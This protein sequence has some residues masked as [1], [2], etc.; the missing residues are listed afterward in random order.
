MLFLNSFD[1]YLINENES[2]LEAIE[3][4][5]KNIE[6]TLYIINSDGELK[7]S[8]SDGDFRRWIIK[9]GNLNAK[10][11]EAASTSLFYFNE[12]VEKKRVAELLKEKGITSC[13]IIDKK[14][15]IKGIYTVKENKLTKEK[16]QMPHISAIIMAGGIG[17]RMKPFTNIL[18]KPLI[19]IGNETMLEVIMGKLHDS[20]GIKNFTLTLNHKAHLIKAYFKELELDYCISSVTEEKP[21]GTAG[22]LSLIN[23]TKISNTFILTNCDI[24]IDADYS[25]IIKFHEKSNYSITIIASL[26]NHTIPY[27]VCHLNEQGDLESITEKPSSGHLISTGMYIINKKCLKYVKEDRFY[28]MTDFIDDVL[29]DEGRIGVYPISENSLMDTG[30]WDEYTKTLKHFSLESE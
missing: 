14:R 23:Q 3:N 19:P 16:S 29:N 7:A 9:G 11:I 17:S 12:D 20:S 4:L 18:P 28:H 6:K 24:I 13:P 2:I 27:G 8:F 1:S 25:D 21:L 15:R 26:I 22:S 30:Q 5:D 10:I